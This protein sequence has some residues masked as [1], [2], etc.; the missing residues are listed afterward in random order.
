[1][2]HVV[3]SENNE[4]LGDNFVSGTC[5][6]INCKVSSACSPNIKQNQDN[7]NHPGADF[8]GGFVSVSKIRSNDC[9]V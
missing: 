4:L 9:V 5:K 2:F 8:L 6:K 7:E 1:M 3:W